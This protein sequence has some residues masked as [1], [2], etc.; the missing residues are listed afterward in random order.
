MTESNRALEQH[1]AVLEEFRVDLEKL[2]K[3]LTIYIKEN[4][5]NNS[6]GPEGLWSQSQAKPQLLLHERQEEAPESKLHLAAYLRDVGRASLRGIKDI[7]MGNS[8]EEF[9]KNTLFDSYSSVKKIRRFLQEVKY[10]ED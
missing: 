1:G 5:L 9:V 10:L 3:Q 8:G 7:S 2:E 6:Y 4:D